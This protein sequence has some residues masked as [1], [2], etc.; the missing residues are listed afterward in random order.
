[1][2]FLGGLK[3]VGKVALKVAPYAALA[4]PGLGIP[5][6]MALQ[7]AIGAASGAMNHGGLKG[8]LLGGAIGAGTGALGGI[9]KAAT[10]L[11]PS[12]STVSNAVS[13]TANKALGG[14]LG[15]KI[16]STGV[17][18]AKNA[19]ITG[20]TKTEIAK[21]VLS[22]L[23]NLIHPSA[24]PMSATADTGASPAGLS[25]RLGAMPAPSDQYAGGFGAN[26]GED[27]NNP[28]L[29]NSINQGKLDAQKYRRPA[30]IPLQRQYAY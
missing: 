1:M 25:P 13:G 16:L 26:F 9:G 3:K 15:S 11:G 4:I 7:G 6:S 22:K 12:A 28:N 30:G 24:Q 14:G 27:Q 21:S 23:P 10:G 17:N 2:S 19:G 18:M 20:G 5:A 8:A 29:A